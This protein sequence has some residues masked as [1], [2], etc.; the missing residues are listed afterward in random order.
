MTT[1]T[2]ESDLDVQDLERV[3]IRFAGDSGDGMQV[4]GTQFTRTAAVFGND[5]ST[6]PDFP[7]EI[8][9]PAGSLPGVSGF[10]ISFSSSDIHTPGD[11]PDVLVAMN[12]AALKANI[13]DLPA[14]GALIVNSDAFTGPNLTKVGYAANP[15]GDGSLNVVH[16]LRDPDLH[17]QRPGARG[18]RDDQQAGRP[19]Q[20]LLRPRDHVLA[21]RAEHGSDP[22]LDR[23]QVRQATGDR[24]GELSRAQGRLRLRRDDRDL[25]HPLP[26]R[27]RPP[28]PG[29]LSQHHRQ[30]G[31]RPRL[32]RGRAEGRA[33]PVLRLV[34][35]H[36]GQRHPPPAVGLQAPR[37]D[38]VPGG[39]RDRRHRHRRSGRATAARSG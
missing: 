27:S 33:R 22:P 6:L 14:G 32:R 7:A 5:I 26:G 1:T 30:R 19:D 31:D 4:T 8:R 3:T 25:P 35:D 2:R 28:R 29:D 36:P 17:P 37:R 23:G 10:Q 16:G 24:R 20:E 12:P 21:L 18:S 11:E 13:G 38:D 34:S 15:L 39:G 9:A